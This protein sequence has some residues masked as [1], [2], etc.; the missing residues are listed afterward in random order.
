MQTWNQ[1][2]I[3]AHLSA[4]ERPNLIW[5][6]RHGL[7][8]ETL[9]VNP[10]GTLALTP[11]PNGLSN[12]LTDSNVTTDFSDSQLEL[13]T[14]P[15]DSVDAV[16]SNLAAI[17]RRVLSGL[18]NEEKLWPNSMPC[19]LPAVEKIPI[20]TYGD[21]A[22][23]KEKEIYRRGLALRYGKAVQMLCGVHYNLSFSGDLWRFLQQSFGEKESL[24]EF[25]NEACLALIRNFIRQRWWLAY[26]TAAT[27]NHHSTY[28][29]RYT[30]GPA[31]KNTISVR[32]S[33]CGY[34]NPKVVP[35]CYNSFTSHVESLEK[36]VNTPYPPYRALGLE[37]NGEKLQLNDHL[38]QLPN[39]YYFPIRMK[40]LPGTGS[41]LDGLKKR[42]VAYLELR[43]L[44]IDPHEATG[45]NADSLR[46]SHLF[47][48]HCLLS[49]S[50]HLSP[51]DHAQADN[52]QEFVALNGQ[53]ALPESYQREGEALLQA[54][55]PLSKL[56]GAAYEKTLAHFTQQFKHPT[57]L[58]WRRTLDE[59]E[60]REQDF[61]AYNLAK[62]TAHQQTLQHE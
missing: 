34:H 54:M 47:L 45:V 53:A 52:K 39:E 26:L 31:S 51:H 61:I 42:G 10:D 14:A 50:P 59:M 29:C 56:L 22:E 55:V 49:Q 16:L 17:H 41:F 7:E 9:R 19:I 30:H 38:F 25:K 12:P 3:L 24:Q 11:H 44:D 6:A 23:G 48:L 58:P 35:I 13:V 18:E 20:A 1:V 4:L 8:R 62:A 40:P 43:L 37:K 27:P 15:F 33:R 28:S 46:L 21:S 32:M 36:A 2:Q 60:A 5:G 57:I